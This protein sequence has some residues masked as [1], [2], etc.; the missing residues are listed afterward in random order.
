[1]KPPKVGKI[2]ALKFLLLY[3]TKV[4]KTQDK[5]IY[6]MNCNPDCAYEEMLLTKHQWNKADGRQ[7]CHFIQSFSPTDAVTPELA[8]ELGQ[9]LINE[10]EQ[11]QGFEIVMATHVDKNHIHNHFAINSVNAES[12][13]K[14]EQKARD[15]YLLKERCNELCRQYQLSQINL[16]RKKQGEKAQS[17]QSYGEW[18]HRQKGD[19]WKLEL[20]KHIKDCLSY[21]TNKP[22]FYHAM[23]ERGVDVKWTKERAAVTFIIDG[24]KCRN[25]KLSNPEFFSK[26]NMQAILDSNKDNMDLLDDSKDLFLEATRIAGAILNP[27][28]PDYLMFKD[29]NRD[30]SMFEGRE[31]LNAIEQLKLE[32][33]LEITR[34]KNEK[35][36]KK[37]N[38]LSDIL[39]ASA[40]FLEWYAE[41]EDD[42]EID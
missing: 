35:E 37:K 7:Y 16:E 8:H 33:S 40:D 10:F 31:L 15:L 34:I 5:L 27:S 3:I 9:R 13:L 32:Y 20:E 42:L 11:F 1:M 18:K 2:S 39:E 25:T 29:F 19:S 36:R 22:Q 12:G 4:E 21:C 30:L 14:W 38:S 24:I 6:G 26:E 41:Q 28:D 17:D 23:N